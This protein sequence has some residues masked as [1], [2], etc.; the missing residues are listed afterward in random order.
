M[1]SRTKCRSDAGQSLV[2]LWQDIPHPSVSRYLSAM[3]WDFVI[4]DMQHGAMSFE[5]A[6]ECVHSLRSGGTEPWIRVSVGNPAEVQR[7]L[8]IGAQA[9]VVPMVNSFDDARSMARS[10]KYP[11][12]GERSLGGT[13]SILQGGNYPERAN[14]ETLL[15]VQVEHIDAVRAVD[16]ILAIPGVDGCF[17]GPTDLALSMNLSREG[18]ADHLD[19]RRAMRRTLEASRSQG[20]LVCCNTYSLADAKEKVASGFDCITLQSEVQLLMHAGRQLRD[21]LLGLAGRNIS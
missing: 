18:Y 2:G 17:I 15:L 10:A 21:K 11:P 4:L 1:S 16:E 13:Y 20:K 19:H 5:T 12:L 9:V 14:A 6:H 7:A 8:D 3:D